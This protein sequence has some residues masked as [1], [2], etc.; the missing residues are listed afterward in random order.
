MLAADSAKSNDKKI[1]VALA[2]YNGERF[3]QAQLDSFERQSVLPDEIVIGDDDSTDQTINIL[4]NFANSSSIRVKIERNI[5][6]VGYYENFYKTLR[7]CSGDV[8]FLSDQDDVWLDNKIETCLAALQN[9]GSLVVTHD[10]HL[11]DGA[12]R[13]SS[14]TMLE[15]I[16]QSGGGS[17]FALLTGCCMALQR[18]MLDFITPSPSSPHDIWIGKI[19]D[20]LDARSIINEPLILYRRHGSNVSGSH[21]TSLQKSGPVDALRDRFRKSQRTTSEQAVRESLNWTSELIDAIERNRDTVVARVGPAGASEIVEGL[22]AERVRLANRSQIYCGTRFLRPYRV[23]R[24]AMDGGYR[25]NST[26]FSVIRDL[27][28]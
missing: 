27:L 20:I 13:P 19:A 24:F 6:N 18:C 25:R 26:I 7:R 16:A 21:L 23:A 11:V 22:V 9:T 2:T 15:Q 8:I 12:L 14:C 3:L 5:N 10:A 4:E 28:G 1:S 17:E